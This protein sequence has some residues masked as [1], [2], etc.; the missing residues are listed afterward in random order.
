VKKGLPV[1][2]HVM[3]LDADKDTHFGSMIGYSVIKIDGVGTVMS[4]SAKL[5]CNDK[6]RDSLLP[7][8]QVTVRCGPASSPN[9]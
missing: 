8:V 5:Q 1:D 9:K 7:C 6:K 2:C 3:I 4:T